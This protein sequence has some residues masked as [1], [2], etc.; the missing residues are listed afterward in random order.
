MFF[1]ITLSASLLLMT[2]YIPQALWGMFAC[3]FSREVHTDE[4]G[5]PYCR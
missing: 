2:A 5:F 3:A 4:T 1:L